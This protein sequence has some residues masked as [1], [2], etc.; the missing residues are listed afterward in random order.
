MAWSSVG[1]WGTSPNC[2]CGGGGCTCATEIC[3]TDCPGTPINNITVTVGGTQ[4]CVNPLGSCCF[5]CLDS[6]GGAG[7]YQVVVSAP[8][9]VTYNQSLALTCGGVATV[10]LLTT[11]SCQCTF[12]A[13]GCNFLPA[14]NA[15]VTVAGGTYT[16]PVTLCITGNG[17][18]TYTYSAPGFTSQSGTFT[19]TSNC[20]G[21]GDFSTTLS[22]DSSHACCNNPTLDAGDA[23]PFTI[24]VTD[25]LYGSTTIN[26]SGPGWIGVL[27][28]AAFPGTGAPCTTCPPNATEIQYSLSDNPFFPNGCEI[29]IGFLPDPSGFCPGMTGF[30][31]FAD[32]YGGTISATSNPWSI[33]ITTAPCSFYVG[34][35]YTLT[36]R[37]ITFSP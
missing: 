17:T 31:Y 1:A 9:Y 27:S 32:A 18:Y 4:T 10:Q 25:S 37:T 34:P 28:G 26:R 12:A 19:I 8:G 30:A 13:N 2:C 11:G 29:Q 23:I 3:V 24:H 5:V 33:T 7:T 36:P 20:T 35:L 22:P 15:T 16:L 14:P 6:L 21:C